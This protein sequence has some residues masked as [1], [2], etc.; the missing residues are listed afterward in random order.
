MYFFRRILETARWCVGIVPKTSF[1]AKSSR[2]F[3]IFHYVALFIIV[4]VCMVVSG[5]IWEPNKNF[6]PDSHPYWLKR[7]WLGWVV[8][9]VYCLS[10]AIIYL[11]GL[12]K[13]E[14]RPEFED[15]ERCWRAGMEALAREK[16]DMKW[17]PVFLVNGLT[18]K[19]ESAFFKSTASWSVVA[20]N[21]EDTAAVLRFYA[22]SEQIFISC[23][24]V[25]VV[26][27]QIESSSK[28]RTVSTTPGQTAAADV[29]ATGTIRAPSS[30]APAAAFQL[31]VDDPP[32]MGGSLRPGM[33]PRPTAPQP[34]AQP[35][36]PSTGF[37]GTIRN[38]M[39][40]VG[41]RTMLPGGFQKFA[42][43]S[44]PVPSET[45]NDFSAISTDEVEYRLRRM[46]YLTELL[47]TSRDPVC[48]INGLIQATSFDWTG[49]ADATNQLSPMG[50]KDVARLHQRL[51]MQFPITLVLP[52]LQNIKGY[53][54]FM[55]RCSVL[56]PGFQTSRAGSRFSAGADMSSQHTAVLGQRVMSWFRDWVY[57]AFA[58]ELQKSSENR[59]LYLFLCKLSARTRLLNDQIRLTL[60]GAARTS[61]SPNPPEPRLVGCYFAA[62]GLGNEN[63]RA[64]ASGIVKRMREKENEVA[65]SLEA[66]DKDRK[67]C[68]MAY[69]FFG[70]SL[71]LLLALIPFVMFYV[72]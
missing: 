11:I 7:T 23:T 13:I 1:S 52:D 69:V 15:I 44:A 36:E 38:M 18:A 60:E 59:R 33:A 41:E 3:T 31:P 70:L 10:K 56:H 8:L 57:A 62:T 35:S 29:V 24:D 26:S 49:N 58:N 27:K 39:D 63:Q 50:Q 16:L 9:L 53:T 61:Q 48:P 51:G 6:F 47:L 5:F 68:L 43:R 12:L 65:W 72:L 28:A 20:P 21:P 22:N 46:D 30:G 67:R 37:G 14:D 42:D 4:V 2:F 17:I 34:T 64:F 25:G 54:G 66:I 40:F 19:Q 55:R 32:E 71:V 45:V